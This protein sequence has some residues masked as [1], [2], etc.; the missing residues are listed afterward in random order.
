MEDNYPYVYLDEIAG[1]VEIE[2]NEI[3]RNHVALLPYSQLR[4]T[5]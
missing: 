2:T 3:S 5:K 4:K 1:Q